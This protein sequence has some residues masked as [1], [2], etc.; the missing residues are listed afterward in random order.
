MK[1]GLHMDTIC[2]LAREDV[3]SDNR[4]LVAPI[5]QSAV[6]SLASPEQCE[7]VYQGESPGYIYTRDANPNHTALEETLAA[8]NVP[9]PTCGRVNQLVFEP[10]GTV[11]SVRPYACFRVVPEPSVN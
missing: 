5:Y 8:V 3:P 9:C 2:A 4:P 1:P 7:A 6:W 11:R 10:S